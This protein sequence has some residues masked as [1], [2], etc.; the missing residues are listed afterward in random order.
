MRGRGGR[1]LCR[2]PQTCR[3]GVQKSNASTYPERVACESRRER[4][5]QERESGARLSNPSQV[6]SSGIRLFTKFQ[7]RAGSIVILTAALLLAPVVPLASPAAA[8]SQ[9]VVSSVSPGSGTIGTPVTITGSGFNYGCTDGQ[10]GQVYFGGQ[11]AANATVTDGAATAVAPTHEAGAVYVQVED[12]LGDLSAVSSAGTFVYPAPVVSSVSPGS[13]TIGTPVTIT[14]SG[15]N[16]GCTAGQTG[17]VYF[18]G[19]AAANATVTDGAATAVAP[20]HEAGAVYV[21]VED[22]LGDLSA[23]SSA[24]TFV[25]PAPVVSSVS[26]GSGTIGT[27]VT[28]T[29]SG[30]DYGCT[31][32]QTG[33][34][35]FGGQRQ[36]TRP[37]PTGRPQPSRRRTGGGGVREGGRTASAICPRLP[38]LTRSFTRCR[39]LA[40]FRRG[41]GR[42]APASRSQARV[43]IPAAPPGSRARCSSAG[44]R[45]RT[46][47]LATGPPLPSRRRTARRRCP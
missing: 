46:R 12:C 43:S 10:T 27:P 8:A 38:A 25:Y 29:G 16:Y 20:T 11:A 6:D 28:I 23:V 5:A 3:C 44:Y 2:N 47:P 7:M 26:P 4:P 1:K 22:C 15:F 45:Q 35:Y 33:Q 40:Q 36:R 24:G 18:G 42:S 13:G 37:L 30:F 34:V 31:D 19:Q 32:G 9:P 17:Q 21:K 14:G 41:R 39:W